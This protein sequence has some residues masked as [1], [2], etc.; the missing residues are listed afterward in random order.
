MMCNR[1]S[2]V[3]LNAQPIWGLCRR[4]DEIIRLTFI[5]SALGMSGDVHQCA[6]TAISGFDQN[7]YFCISSLRFIM[8][9]YSCQNTGL[10][11]AT[12]TL[13]GC[14]VS[15]TQGWKVNRLAEHC[16]HTVLCTYCNVKIRNCS[17]YTKLHGMNNS[18]LLVLLVC[19]NLAYLTSTSP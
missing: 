5:A 4:L 13:D 18:L 12:H 7:A 14:R 17:N 2:D 16:Y 9:C 15:S 10:N 19:A 3:N 11:F 1:I 8:I 6:D